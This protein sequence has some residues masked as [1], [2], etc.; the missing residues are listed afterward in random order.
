MFV[1]TLEQLLYDLR[2]ELNRSVDPSLTVADRPHL[3]H[4]LNR[5]YRALVDENDWPHLR[6]DFP[7]IPLNTNQRYYDPPTGLDFKRIEIARLWRD[8]CPY[9]LVRGIGTEEY[10][11]YDSEAGERSEPVLRYDFRYIVDDADPVSNATQIEVWPVPS[12]TQDTLQFVG[13]QQTPEL[14]NESDRCMIDA[15]ILVLFAAANIETD[16]ARKDDLVAQGRDRLR[17]LK[18]RLVG[19]S[20]GIRMG[21][22]TADEKP[23]SWPNVTVT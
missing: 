19:E 15:D 2:A 10:A 13:I 3:T 20:R 7:R 22:G 8:G 11:A 18:N 12:V 1:R 14:V 16:K 9:D 6:R 4:M 17:S 23:P 21:L 5:T